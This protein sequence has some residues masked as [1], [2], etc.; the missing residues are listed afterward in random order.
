MQMVFDAGYA[1]DSVEGGQLGLASF[2]MNLLDEGA[3]RMDA[4]DIAARA[5][6]LGANLNTGAGLDTSS[7]TLSAL[8]ANLRPSVELMATVITD[9]SFRDEDIDRVRAQTLNGIQQEMANPIAIALRMLPPEMFGEGHAYSVPFT[10]SGTP[11]AVTGFTRADLLAH[12]QAW[13]RPDN[14]VLLVA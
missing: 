10:G 13:L 5:E 9:P 6:S 8:T 4:T 11:E 2:T 7:V 1:A 14:A 3:G 12:Q